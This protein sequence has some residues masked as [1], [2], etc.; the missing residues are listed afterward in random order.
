MVEE[1]YCL[2]LKEACNTVFATWEGKFSEV[3]ED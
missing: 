2:D 1:N 3:R